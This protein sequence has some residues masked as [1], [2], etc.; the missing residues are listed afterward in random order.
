MI[1]KLLTALIA[2]IVSLVVSLLTIWSNR[3]KLESEE[4][5]HGLDHRRR[6]TE[7]ILDLRLAAY[8]KAFGITYELTY[9]LLLSSN[10]V[11]VEHILN[12]KEKLVE[13]ERSDGAFLF[14][15]GSLR[16]YRDLLTALSEEPRGENGFSRKQRDRIWR[17]K[18]RFRGALKAD[19]KLLYEDDDVEQ[20]DAPDKEDRASL[21]AP[22]G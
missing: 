6:L 16:A 20:A 21:A 8:P 1:E 7:K 14:S 10:V 17:C 5:R 4:R 18:N 15:K 19:L 2:A 11:P 3:R 22:R 9:P 13:W 12:V